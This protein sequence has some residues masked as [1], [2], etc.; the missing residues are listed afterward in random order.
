MGLLTLAE[1]WVWSSDAE[2]NGK[3]GAGG[4]SLGHDFYWK[5]LRGFSHKRV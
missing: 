4:G 3:G 5:V 1:N 2:G